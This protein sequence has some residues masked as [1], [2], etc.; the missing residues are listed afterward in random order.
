MYASHISESGTFAPVVVQNGTFCL[1]RHLVNKLLWL[2]LVSYRKRSLIFAPRS[3]CRTL[4]RPLP[5]RDPHITD[6]YIHFL[7]IY[8]IIEVAI[9]LKL[10]KAT[11]LL[12]GFRLLL[13]LPEVLVIVE[14]VTLLEPFINC[15]EGISPGHLS[16]LTSR[17]QTH[18]THN[19]KHTKKLL[20]VWLMKQDSTALSKSSYIC[21]LPIASSAPQRRTTNRVIATSAWTP[22]PLP[23]CTSRTSNMSSVSTGLPTTPP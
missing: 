3:A 10:Q 16:M 15:S 17:T 7:A 4:A 8:P 6:V 20:S 9:I 14:P 12:T 19:I 5:I 21:S 1:K 22:N 23:F 18:F 13:K 2:V 11:C